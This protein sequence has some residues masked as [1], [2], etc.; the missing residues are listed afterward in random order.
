MAT[1]YVNQARTTLYIVYDEHGE[2][3]YSWEEEA[4]S[5]AYCA[6]H[7]GYHYEKHTVGPDMGWTRYY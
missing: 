2:M 5:A 7:P 6:A 4:K 3:C 1:R